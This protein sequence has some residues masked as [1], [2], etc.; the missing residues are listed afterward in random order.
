MKDLM[1]VVFSGREPVVNVLDHGFVRLVDCMPRQIHDE[2]TTADHAIAEAAR[3]SYKRG[4][5]TIRDDQ[6]LIRYLMRH[7]HTSP[8]EMVEFKF[9]F[10]LPIFVARQF[11]RH[12]TANVN[13]LSGRYSEIPEEFYVPAD[14]NIR[15]QS[16]INTQGSEGAVDTDLAGDLR[17]KLDD[18]CK[19]A[20]ASYHELLKHDVAREQ[21]RLVMPL[22]AYTEW[23][24]KIDLHNLLR[25][26]DLRCDHHAQWEAQ[27]YA[28]AT[29]ELIRPIVPWTIE[30]WEDYSF[31]RGGVQLTRFEVE[32]I[33]KA[34]KDQKIQL[35]Q[36]DSDNKL[37]QREWLEKAKKL[38]F[39]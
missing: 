38:G 37:E 20:F 22:N 13:E 14:D 36:I 7:L 30:A 16:L 10:K 21:A 27:Q 39:V 15:L 29:L 11:I 32:A 26:L 1:S 25:F 34:L 3:C 28:N 5:K 9:H 6:Q 17:G 24:W 35:G 8:L 23:Y 18:Q 12:R 4:T 19:S 31:Y 2:E 33:Q